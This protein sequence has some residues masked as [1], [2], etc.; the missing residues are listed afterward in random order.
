MID[1]TRPSPE[2][3]TS[4]TDELRRLMDEGFRV[5]P[6]A[7]GDRKGFKGLSQEENTELWKL[8]GGITNDK[9]ESLFGNEAYQKLPD[10]KKGDVI[11][12]VVNQSKINARAGLAIQL[13]EGLSG[14]ELKKKLAELK[15]GGLLTREVL[16]KYMELR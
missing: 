4:V 9:L 13:T 2:V 15:E 11:E 14:D 6:T 12:K 10:D 16:N 5:S 3:G 1:P 8:A 7:L